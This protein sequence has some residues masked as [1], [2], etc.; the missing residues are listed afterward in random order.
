MRQ[1]APTLLDLFVC[2][3][4]GEPGKSEWMKV[5]DVKA[6]GASYQT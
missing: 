3:I 2:L 6:G 1:S 4:S 5:H